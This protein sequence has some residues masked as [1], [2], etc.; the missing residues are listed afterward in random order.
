MQF[1]HSY[2]LGDGPWGTRRHFYST[3]K[4][5]YTHGEGSMPTR[6]INGGQVAY[7]ILGEALAP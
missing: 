1:G 6:D 3:K 7:E 5:E 4:A 2:L